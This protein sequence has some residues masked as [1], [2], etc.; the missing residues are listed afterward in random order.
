[1]TKKTSLIIGKIWATLNGIDT[2]TPK[3]FQSKS[4]ENTKNPR[5]RRQEKK[6]KCDEK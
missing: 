3:I 6:E 4:K 5:K 2:D 1:M